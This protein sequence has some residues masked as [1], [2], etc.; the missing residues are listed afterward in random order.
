MPN[1]IRIRNLN[2]ETNLTSGVTFPVD[3]DSY[4]ENAKRVNINDLKNYILLGATG[5]TYDLSKYLAV[6]GGTLTGD[7]FGTNCR[8]NDINSPLIT[9]WVYNGDYGLNSVGI[10]TSANRKIFRAGVLATDLLTGSNGFT[11]NWNN[12]TNNFI[13]LF[14]QG[15]VTIN[16]NVTASSIIKAGGGADQS[17]QADGSDR[18]LVSGTYFPNLS[19]ISDISSSL[20]TH[21]TYSRVGDV[22]HVKLSGY[23]TPSGFFPVLRFGLPTTCSMP[24][25]VKIGI[26]TLWNWSY[27]ITSVGYVETNINNTIYFH[28]N[29]SG[30]N[31]T[32]LTG[33]NCD[34]VTEFDYSLTGG[35]TT[36]TT[37]TIVGPTT[38]TTTTPLPGTTTTTTTAPILLYGY[39]GNQYTSGS[40]I[41]QYVENRVIADTQSNLLSGKYY[42]LSD[43]ADYY[44]FEILVTGVDISGGGYL[45]TTLT[46]QQEFCFDL[47]PFPVS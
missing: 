31:L 7:L 28:S 44:V 30:T 39:S 15:N 1:I 40:G 6:S 38:T 24:S 2:R 16:Q 14:E 19:N 5:G 46:N 37:T 32:G 13:Y 33:K 18:I 20:L 41:C 22:I 21:A 42:L 11:V 17:L 12:S 47:L 27:G 4:T 36:T 9:A 25:G 8:F 10:D 34:F 29:I 3:N 43:G 35:I 26:G 23:L 45:I